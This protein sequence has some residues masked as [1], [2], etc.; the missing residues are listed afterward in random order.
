MPDDVR[1]AIEWEILG[2]LA[3]T[4]AGKFQ[5]LN[6]PVNA[7]NLCDDRNI[8]FNKWSGVCRAIH[9]FL[10]R[11]FAFFSRQYNFGSAGVVV[12]VGPERTPNTKKWDKIKNFVRVRSHASPFQLSVFYERTHRT[13]SSNSEP[14]FAGA[15]LTFKAFLWIAVMG[16]GIVNLPNIHTS[17]RTGTN[18]CP[19]GFSIR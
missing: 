17:L 2:A 16:I 15:F 10:A 7:I 6:N 18:L 3:G 12:Q 14:N 19:L 13:R 8:E 9:A 11:I 1:R 5:W 4:I